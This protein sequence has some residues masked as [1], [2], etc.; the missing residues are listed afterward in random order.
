MSA[1][2]PIDIHIEEIVNEILD[3]RETK[4]KKEDAEEIV[5]AII[6]K[7]EKIAS[8]IIIK[9]FKALAKHVQNTLRDPEEK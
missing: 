2:N 4:L 3:A 5:K 8:K 1:K 9:H 6:P 7:I